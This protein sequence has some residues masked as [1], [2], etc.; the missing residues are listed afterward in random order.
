MGNDKVTVG[1]T[2]DGDNRLDEVMESEFFEEEL[3][4]YRVAISVALAHD[5]ATDR[6]QMKKVR[7]KF[8]VGSLEEDGRLRELIEVLRPYAGADQVFSL[9][10][11]LADAGLRILAERVRND[12]PLRDVLLTEMTTD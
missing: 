8:N 2:P 3:T 5:V 9:A 11:R 7:T 12:K 6:D 10:E 4:A 1:L